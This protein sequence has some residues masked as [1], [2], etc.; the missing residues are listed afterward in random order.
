VKADNDQNGWGG[1]DD[2]IFVEEEE[3]EEAKDPGDHIDVLPVAI[4]LD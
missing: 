1:E 4:P 2:E 3:E